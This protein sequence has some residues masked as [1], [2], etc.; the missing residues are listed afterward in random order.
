MAEIDVGKMVRKSFHTASAVLGRIEA[1]LC[2][3]SAALGR[4]SRMCLDR[5]VKRV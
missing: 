3:E 1:C 4:Q 5:V 2:N